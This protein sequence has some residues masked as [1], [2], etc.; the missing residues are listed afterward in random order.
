MVNGSW[1]RIYDSEWFMVNSDDCWVWLTPGLQSLRSIW[2]WALGARQFSFRHLHRFL[3][4]SFSATHIHRLRGSAVRCCP[5]CRVRENLAWSARRRSMSNSGILKDTV[6]P[7]EMWPEVKFIMQWE[8]V[9]E[10]IT[11]D[12]PARSQLAWS[13]H[14]G[15]HVMLSTCQVQQN[16]VE[17]K[18]QV[19]IKGD[20]MARNST[21]L[22]PPNRQQI[23]TLTWQHWLPRC[24]GLDCVYRRQERYGQTGRHC[25]PAV[26]LQSSATTC[27]QSVCYVPL[28]SHGFR[29]TLCSNQWNWWRW[30]SCPCGPEGADGGL[31]VV[32]GWY[33]PLS[34]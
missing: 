1:P 7:R 15:K 18:R 6:T 31:L 11:A 32:R 12:M 14:A 17:R 19:R 9:Y 22:D 27:R 34:S 13:P 8:D 5:T 25:P 4:R 16:R 10:D 21:W 20:N 33:M 23:M 30:W 29:R 24:A 26:Q 28:V 3:L 2:A